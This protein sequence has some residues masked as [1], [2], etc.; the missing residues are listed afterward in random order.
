MHWQCDER[1]GGGGGQAKREEE[2]RQTNASERARGVEPAYYAK[3]KCLFVVFVVLCV[4]V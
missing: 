4:G 3:A 1:E 2:E